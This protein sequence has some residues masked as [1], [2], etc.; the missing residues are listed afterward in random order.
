LH[1]LITGFQPLPDF[2]H[3]AFTLFFAELSQLSN[4][5]YIFIYTVFILQAKVDEYEERSR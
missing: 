3:S 4:N 5:A 1:T 2:T